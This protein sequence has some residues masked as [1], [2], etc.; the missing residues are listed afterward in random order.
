MMI[1]N[2]FL[3]CVAGMVLLATPANAS[4]P[5]K[6]PSLLGFTDDASTTAGIGVLR[7][8]PIPAGSTELRVWIGF[9]A[10]APDRM[11]RLRTDSAGTVNGQV[12]TYF[13]DGFPHGTPQDNS[14]FLKDVLRH[15]TD[16][17]KGKS[18]DV[19]APTFEHRPDWQKLRDQ[20]VALGIETL[21]DERSLP[22]PKELI[23]SLDGVGMVVEFRDGATY[24]AYG[25]SWPNFRDAP[26]VAT[27]SKIMQLVSRTLEK[28]IGE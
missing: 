20:L 3:A 2:E 19:C 14:R 12:L 4:G 27:A 17:K 18:T 25:Y 8:A 5:D 13:P 23:M 26:E 22:E 1:R 9:G 7:D 11:L 28:A 10:T 15:C 6:L 21:P 16:L 24:R